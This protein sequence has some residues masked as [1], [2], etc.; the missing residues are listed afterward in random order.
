MGWLLACTTVFLITEI[1]VQDVENASSHNICKHV[2]KP[3]VT[4]LPFEADS[5]SQPPTPSKGFQ[6]ASRGSTGFWI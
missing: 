4:D 3:Q 5:F 1:S 2:G 6:Q